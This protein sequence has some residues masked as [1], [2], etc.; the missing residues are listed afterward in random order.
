MVREVEWLA[1]AVRARVLARYGGQLLLVMAALAVP[2][3]VV[4]AAGG[5]LGF[6]AR[7]G[8]SMAV[9]VGAGLPLS[10]CAAPSDVRPAEGMVVA[11]GAFLL[12]AVAMVPPMAS[13]DLPLLD[14]LFECVSG[15][16]TTGLSTLATVDTRSP[17]F[18]FTRAWMQ[19]YGGLGVAVFALV[20]VTRPGTAARQLMADEDEH[21]LAGGT[22]AR[23]RRVLRTYLALTAVAAV[24]IVAAGASPWDGLLTTLSATSTGGFAPHDGS[25]AALGGPALGGVVLLFC[26]IGAVLHPFYRPARRGRLREVWGDLQVR[27]L[28]LA[29]LA[30]SAG[31]LLSLRFGLGMA[32]GDA[33]VE[34][35][36]LAASAQT[37]TGFFHTS[38]AGIDGA[39][40]V[41]V[42]VSMFVGGGV[43]STAG[44]IKLVRLLILLRSVQTLVARVVLPQHAVVGTRLEG[45]TL[46]EEDLREAMLV[47]F[48]FLSVLVV[49]W[50]PFVAAGYDPLDALFDVTSAVGTVGLSTGV[51]GPGLPGYL[52]GILCAEMLL[53]RLEIIAWLVI[54]YPRTWTGRRRG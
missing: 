31:L 50:L 34:A 36:L 29:T 47:I 20:F 25:L 46:E 19:W 9:L 42:A 53:G 21:E 48:L 43:G 33:L 37:T 10:R 27:V 13:G 52:K 51:V 45:R 5:E 49:S 16:T 12:A 54:L 4:A 26:G 28:L 6:L 22:R 11:A 35:P 44:G 14:A 18:L 7:L 41:L 39:S 30:L 15:V 38:P 24:A 32:W 40:K 2:P 1:R 17:A 23:A 3:A 8:A